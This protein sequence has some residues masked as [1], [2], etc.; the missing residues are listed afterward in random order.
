MSIRSTG[1]CHDSV[2]V[3]L[4]FF[5]SAAV[6]TLGSIL[7]KF[8]GMVVTYIDNIVGLSRARVST[9]ATSIEYQQSCKMFN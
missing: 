3:H 9:Y 5:S 1:I 2:Q 6:M 8:S 4:K 7:F